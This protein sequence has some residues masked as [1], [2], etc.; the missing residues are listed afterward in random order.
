[1]EQS[2]SCE[3][4]RF[5]ASHEIPHILWN[6]KDHY[7]IY[8]CPPP[9]PTLSQIN[10][11][12]ARPS[13]FLKIHLNIIVPFTTGSSEWSL[14]LRFPHQNPVYT[15]PLPHSATCPTHLFLLNF[16][17]KPILGLLPRNIHTALYSNTFSKYP[18]W[19]YIRYVTQCDE[20][21]LDISLINWLAAD[22]RGSHPT[23]ESRIL[24]SITPHQGKF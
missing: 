21:T 19:E 2:P 3:V 24:V 5:S 4:N 6:P 9:V 16:I 10:P 7:R 23:Q 15:S 14:S 11:V 22:D 20:I 13:H 1:M 17:T 8:K 18:E 12:H